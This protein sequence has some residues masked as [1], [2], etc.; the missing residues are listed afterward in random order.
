MIAVVKNMEMAD[1]ETKTSYYIE[2][3]RILKSLMI[4]DTP[5]FYHFLIDSQTKH[6]FIQELAHLFVFCG[7]IFQNEVKYNFLN[8]YPNFCLFL[9]PYNELKAYIN[10]F[11]LKIKVL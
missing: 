6:E 3:V 11:N 10:Y 4:Y 7:E 5:Y 8:L 9:I 2:I 1:E